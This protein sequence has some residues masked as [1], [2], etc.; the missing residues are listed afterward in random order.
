MLE[1]LGDTAFN[2]KKAQS[3]RLIARYVHSGNSIVQAASVDPTTGIFTTTQ[4]MSWTANTIYNDIIV[5]Y[6]GG[7]PT[8]LFSEWNGVNTYGLKV[9]DANTFYIVNG[10]SSNTVVTYATGQTLVDLAK[11]QFE[12]VAV[13]PPSIDLTGITTGDK[14]RLSWKGIKNRPGYIVVSPNW[15]YTGGTGVQTQN[16]IDGR[17]FQIA[18]IE[19]ICEYNREMQMLYFYEGR[20]ITQAWNGGTSWALNS[21]MGSERTMNILPNLV[22]TRVTLGNMSN[23]TTVEVYGT[24]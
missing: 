10:T 15:S 18:F 4:P 13:T 21:A 5:S 1:W 20:T 16:A 8:R 6:V 23:N 11:I 14:I 7:I 24:Y 3:E 2:Q 9:I 17:C 19:V 22:F 12:Y